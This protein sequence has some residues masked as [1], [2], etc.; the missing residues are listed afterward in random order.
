MAGDTGSNIIIQ[1]S[2]N[3]A[4]MGTDF[5]SG[6]DVGLTNAH[7]PLSKIAWG[8]ST[9]SKRVT[10]TQPL[11]VKVHGTTGSIGVTWDTGYAQE[12]VNFNYHHEH[13]VN[14]DRSMVY[15]AV[16]GSTSGPSNDGSG[17]R[18]GTS[19][20]VWGVPGATAIAITGDV[21][22]INT[23]TLSIN[24]ATA[25]Y[26]S[27]TGDTSM[28]WDQGTSGGFGVPVN[29][30]GGRRAYHATDSILV[31]GSVDISGGRALAAGTDSIKVYGYDGNQ[32]VH[33]VLRANHDGT[34][35]GFS[36]DALKVALTNV[37]ITCSVD[38][39]ATLGVTNDIK[40]AD[41]EAAHGAL[42][43]QGVSGGAPLVIRGDNSGAVE[44]TATSALSTTVT[45][46]VS[47]NDTNITNSLE[48]NSKPLIQTLESIN[49]KVSP[50]TSIRSDLTGGNIRVKVIET[51]RPNT[52]ISGTQMSTS[53]AAP[54]ASNK[55]VYSGVNIKS[56]PS[57]TSDVMVGGSDL[58]RNA[59]A[60][61]P[62]EPGESIFIECDN[63]SKVYIR[64]KKERIHYI[65]S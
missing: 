47:I 11:P 10:E 65:G 33:T 1:I 22:L 20:P 46:T 38:L 44:V 4:E 55:S 43:V 63:L 8:D 35:L 9:L 40:T 37:G 6:G 31:T 24:G 51:I 50:V 27:A 59:D 23:S 13:L 62:L 56:S 34:T 30:T 45:G 54:L 41:P 48:S 5:A 29:I 14:N 12:V 53:S 15:L 52:V 64:G 18:V 60:G 61:Y 25:G 58:I 42:K 39:S 57:N 26:A 49:T 3:T 21:R 19:G 36:G 17:G 7:V 28:E 32:A 2:G 16:A